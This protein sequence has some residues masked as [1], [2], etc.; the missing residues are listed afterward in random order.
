MAETGGVMEKGLDWALGG[1]DARV[2]ALERRMEEQQRETNSQLRTMR[3][4]NEKLD[5]KL[6]RISDTLIA[7]RSSRKAIFWFV[8]LIATASTV[9]ATLY[10]IGVIR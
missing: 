3:T 6:D 4:Q 9:V 8:G 1:L 5:E 2:S 10:Q 7:D